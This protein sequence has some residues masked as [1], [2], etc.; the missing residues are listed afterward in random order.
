MT[1]MI[2]KATRTAPRLF[3][4]HDR[5]L[6][7]LLIGAGGNGSE[8][9]D[10]LLR[11]HTALTA[12]G[13]KGLLVTVMDDDEVSPSNI[14]RQRFWPHEVGTNKAIALTHRANTMLGTN[15]Q[16]VPFRLTEQTR[17]TE[18]PDLVI[19]AVDNLQARRMA[20]DLFSKPRRSNIHSEVYWLDMGCDKDKAQ[21]VFGRF[22]DDKLTDEWPSV[23]AHFPDLAI[24]EDDENAPSCSAAESLARQDLMVNGAIANAAVNILWKL[25]REGK[26]AFNGVM[27]DLSSGYSQGMKFLPL[28]STQH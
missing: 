24:R 19:T 18:H 27:L 22:G 2:E 4:N 5:P 11:L 20:N 23:M 1:T 25:M 10:G 14:V 15:W 9:F 17:L 8:C 13:G 6:R 12:L 16:G 28:N 21:A 3:Q 7:V 26:L